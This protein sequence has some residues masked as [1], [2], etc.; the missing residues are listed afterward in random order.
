[1]T[2][3]RSIGHAKPPSGFSIQT[4]GGKLESSR[5]A[6]ESGAGFHR[7]GS[8]EMTIPNTSTTSHTM[9]RSSFPDP[10]RPKQ[11]TGEWSG[12]QATEPKRERWAFRVTQDKLG[13]GRP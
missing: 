5:I 2:F 13:K 1:M 12:H 8:S 4:G 3:S 7:G 11:P 9:A 6:P 10:R